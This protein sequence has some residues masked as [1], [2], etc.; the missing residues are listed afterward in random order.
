MLVTGSKNRN[1]DTSKGLSIRLWQGGQSFCEPLPTLTSAPQSVRLVIEGVDCVAF[2]RAIAEQV[3][4]E[5]LLRSEG[6]VVSEGEEVVVAC[7][8]SP[9]YYALKVNSGLLEEAREWAT[10]WGLE[11][12]Y[13]TPLA[14]SVR[15]AVVGG[16]RKRSLALQF[17]RGEVYVALAAEGQLLFAEAVI[18]EGEESLLRLLTVLN[19]DF[20]LRK[21]D[22][23]VSGVDGKMRTKWLGHYFRHCK[24]EK[25]WADVYNK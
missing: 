12:T 16:R 4:V 25:E 8:Q 23:F 14:A 19:S 9:L 5:E 11:L 2:P 21:A 17:G 13:A 20:D 6:I 1:S 3:N 10:Q 24:C 15:R 7:D 18:V 22:L